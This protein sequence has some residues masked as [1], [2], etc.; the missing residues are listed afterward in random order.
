M[1][2]IKSAKKQAIQ[3]QKR[4]A[5]NLARKT[6]VKTAMK[7]V[8]TALQDGQSAQDVQ[9][10]FNEAQAKCARAKNKGLYHRNTSARKISRLALKIKNHFAQDAQPAQV[11]PKKAKK[12]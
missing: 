9:Q 5:I 11:A 8:V 3:S 4:H 7:K 10:L 6:G 2:N 1:A 12:A